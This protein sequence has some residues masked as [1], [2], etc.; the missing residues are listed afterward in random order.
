MLY[1]LVWYKVHVIKKNRVIFLK[2]LI[3][4][5]LMYAVFVTVRLYR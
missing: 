2:K 4:P 1:Y 5:N 3:Y